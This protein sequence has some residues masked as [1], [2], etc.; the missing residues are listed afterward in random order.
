MRIFSKNI[1]TGP[2]RII[3]LIGPEAG[4]RRPQEAALTLCLKTAKKGDFRS[5]IPSLIH[6]SAFAVRGPFRT[7]N[8]D[9]QPPQRGSRQL[10]FFSSEYKFPRAQ[11]S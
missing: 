10:F 7:V 5:E 9:D 2:G 4:Q 8:S 3:D 6:E 1:P 11:S